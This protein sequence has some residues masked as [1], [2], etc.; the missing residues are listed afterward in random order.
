[1]GPV[2]VGV[3][4]TESDPDQD[5]PPGG[6]L[7]PQAQRAV[8]DPIRIGMSLLLGRAIIGQDAVGTA[9][10]ESF[11]QMAHG[12]GGEA[13]GRREAGGR[14]AELGALEQLLPHGNRD[15]LWH[16]YRLRAR[17][18]RGRIIFH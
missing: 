8:A 18:S 2:E 16:R 1:M 13:E 15:G 6:V 14:L 11:P 12:S 7:S 10:A 4:H 17:V 9:V 3:S 5:R